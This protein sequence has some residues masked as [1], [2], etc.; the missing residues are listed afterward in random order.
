L[1]LVYG[2]PQAPSVREGWRGSTALWHRM[3]AQRGIQVITLDNR[4]ASGLGLRD[5]WPSYRKLGEGELRD[6]EDAIKALSER[7][8]L[9]PGAIALSGW[10]Y[11]GYFTSYALTHSKLFK[12]G[13]A[14]APV[15]DWR[16]YDAIYTERYM[17]LPKD[18]P[19]GYKSSSV[20]AAADSLSGRLILIH[21]GL[22]DNV[23]PS[24][25]LQLL[26][27]LQERGADCDLWYYPT[28]THGLRSYNLYRDLRLRMTRELFSILK[29]KRNW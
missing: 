6:L 13:F 10:S 28:S 2:G 25:S 19:E 14:G 22:D 24:N 21:G 18:N 23:H 29:P 26:E 5:A 8:I 27:A 12:L 9:D 15:T 17:G 1:I 11:G 16:S 20:L 7:K 4:L 3:L